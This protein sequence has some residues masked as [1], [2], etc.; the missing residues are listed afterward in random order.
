ME[1]IE[2]TVAPA[3]GRTSTWKLIYD[4]TVPGYYVES[5][6]IEEKPTSSARGWQTDTLF[7]M[8]LGDPKA[9]ALPLW[10]A[11]CSVVASE[12]VGWWDWLD[13]NSTKYTAEACPGDVVGH[14]RVCE[15]YTPVDPALADKV[16]V[17]IYDGSPV[18][19]RW[20]SAW[21]FG[22]PLSGYFRQI[23]QMVGQ[24]MSLIVFRGVTPLVASKRTPSNPTHMPRNDPI[25][26]PFPG[27][28]V[29]T[30]TS[31]RRSQV[32][33]GASAHVAT[34]E[35]GSERA[36]GEGGAEGTLNSPFPAGK[37]TSASVMQFTLAHTHDMLLKK[38]NTSGGES[39]F[40][41]DNVNVADHMGE[42]FFYS[43]VG[44]GLA[45]A[46]G[47]LFFMSVVEIQV[48]THWGVYEG[49]NYNTCSRELWKL[50]ITPVDPTS[51]AIG[52]LTFGNFFPEVADKDTLTA[53]CGVAQAFGTWYNLAAAGKCEPGATPADGS[54]TWQQMRVIK[55]IDARKC[56]VENAKL[57]QQVND[58]V[59][60]WSKLGR[61]PVA[62]SEAMTAAFASNDPS[63]GGCVSL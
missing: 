42:A 53:Q 54:C 52:R 48:D 27:E 11:G 61:P 30:Q 20:P 33:C 35:R 41:L 13:T 51:S 43:F 57:M 6:V 21:Y 39:V 2:W 22:G 23:N 49:C 7:G 15:S 38:E 36:G 45:P 58:W 62:M 3:T 1:Y 8:D 17:W 5:L 4:A 29:C 44:S 40:A 46:L 56:F 14:T 32:L 25:L 37:N 16:R 9:I 63:L 12:W 10:P 19:L 47:D 60:V 59:H 34:E 50:P 55:T 28:S 31:L 24:Q 18:A 26:P